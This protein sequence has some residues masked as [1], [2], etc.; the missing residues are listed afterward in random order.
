MMVDHLCM[1]MYATS[2]QLGCSIVAVLL[3]Y[4][5]LVSFMWMLMEGVVLYILLVRVFVE[6]LQK[7]YI[8]GFTVVSYGEKIVITIQLSCA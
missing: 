6:G 2:S 7:T 5:F 8:I 1:Y 3:H 4:L